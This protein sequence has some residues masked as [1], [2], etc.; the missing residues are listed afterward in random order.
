MTD[1]RAL[2]KVDPEFRPLLLE[3]DQQA[4]GSAVVGWVESGL[5][6]R[7]LRG[8]KM[9]TVSGL[10]D[11]FAAALQFPLYFGENEDAFNECIAELETLPA[12]EGYVV[13]ITDPDQVLAHAGPEALGWLA[14]AL[15]SA[16]EEWS[17]SVELGEWWDRP[18]VPFHVVLA[19][20]NDAI[21]LATRRWSGAG[22][23]PVPFGQA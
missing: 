12:G 16:A 21:A 14:R 15:E 8:R 13:T 19:G 2:L 7:I 23:V 22:S 4:I 9:R 11:E 18:P 6:A 20:E 17:Q 5:T 10:F 1:V 3:G